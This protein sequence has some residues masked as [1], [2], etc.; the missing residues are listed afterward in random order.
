VRPE[1]STLVVLEGAETGALVA[2]RVPPDVPPGFL[3]R[4]REESGWVRV[5]LPRRLDDGADGLR[6][7]SYRR[8][9]AGVNAWSKLGLTLVF[10][11][12]M[13]AAVTRGS[14]MAAYLMFIIA[15]IVVWNWPRRA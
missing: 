15:L 4:G 9:L 5:V 6:V 11:A 14:T 1:S 13:L 3:E 10:G 7:G 12:L 8:T 2:Y